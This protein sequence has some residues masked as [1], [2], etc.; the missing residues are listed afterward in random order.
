MINIST[1][2]YYIGGIM[3]LYLS[4]LL[5]FILILSTLSP[6]VSANALSRPKVYTEHLSNCDIE[7]TLISDWKSGYT[8]QIKITNKSLLPLENWAF[9]F[10]YSNKIT[11]IWNAKILYNQDQSYVLK[12]TDYNQDILPGKSVTIGFK[13]TF[14]GEIGIPSGFVSLGKLAVESS[15]NYTYDFT[16]TSSWNSGFIGNL[17][18]N[19]LGSSRIED[20]IIEFDYPGEI[21]RFYDAIILSHIGNHYVIKNVGYNANIK[22]QQTMTLL[23]QGTKYSAYKPVHFQLKSMILDENQIYKSQAE[24]LKVQI[25]SE[26]NMLPDSGNY[27]VDHSYASTLSMVTYYKETGDNYYMYIVL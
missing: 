6:T 3:K 1:Y 23:F 21:S 24:K 5:V 14:S 10:N 17:I 18:V 11:S 8:S 20:W 16:K 27:M 12:C 19:N 7:Y 15:T 4:K 13:G 22:A 26:L 9:F 2:I 25:E